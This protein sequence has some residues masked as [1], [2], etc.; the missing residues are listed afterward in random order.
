MDHRGAGRRAFIVVFAGR[1]GRGC[2]SR[3]SR[4]RTGG[5]QWL[6]RVGSAPG[7]R[8]PGPGLIRAGVTCEK[9]VKEVAWGCMLWV[10]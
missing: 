1:S 2:R 10:A 5:F 3:L 9:P 6:C 4:F 8:A 7:C